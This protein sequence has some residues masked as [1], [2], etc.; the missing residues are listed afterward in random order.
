[1]PAPFIFGLFGLIVGSFLNVLIVRHGKFSLFGRSACTSCGKQIAAFD[2]IPVLSWLILRG[3][4]RACGS[5]L[6]VQYPL[7]EIATCLAFVVIGAA[8]LPLLI[9]LLA[10][11]IAALLIAITV[12]DLY[13]TIIPDAWVYPFAGLSLV[14]SFIGMYQMQGGISL[15][16]AAGPVVA[17]PLFFLWLY[18]RGTWMGLGDAKLALG[19]GWLLGLGGG[20][21]ALFS[22]FLIGAFVSLLLLFFS[23]SAWRRFKERFIP[24]DGLVSRRAG[25]TMKSEIPFGPFLVASCFLIWLLQMYGIPLTDLIWSGGLPW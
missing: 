21:L 10:L 25:F 3:R 17:A 2:L 23:S 19:M 11:P 5:A 18:S 24:H 20:L 16:A 8:P 15:L 6:S 13:H 1:M 9:R 4:C 12:Y 14:V 7:V 22:A